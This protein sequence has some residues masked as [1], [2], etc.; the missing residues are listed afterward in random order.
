M[1]KTDHENWIIGDKSNINQ[2][3]IMQETPNKQVQQKESII[4][5]NG[6]N[7]KA[8][9]RTDN[10]DWDWDCEEDDDNNQFTNTNK[11]AQN[12]YNQSAIS[13]S[14]TKCRQPCLQPEDS[15]RVDGFMKTACK[16]LRCNSC[17]IV[18][19]KFKG[20]RWNEDVINYQFFRTNFGD[21]KRLEPGMI[22]D[23]E[24]AVYSCGCKGVS[25]KEGIKQE[26]GNPWFCTGCT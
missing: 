26:Q 11:H 14:Q 15:G 8:N 25:V 24:S 19:H 23:S 5:D 6:K 7:G 9:I 13:K 16:N 20:Y 12:H 2:E 18:V 3:K 10:D 22:K 1:S 17:G 4:K 21:F